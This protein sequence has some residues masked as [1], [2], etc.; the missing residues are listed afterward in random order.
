VHKVR[1]SKKC[2]GGCGMI[3]TVGSRAH[4]IHGGEWC[5]DCAL[6]HFRRAPTCSARL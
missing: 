6:R 5:D 4:R 2:A 1:M 3:L